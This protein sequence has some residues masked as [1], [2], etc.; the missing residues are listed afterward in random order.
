MKS[1]RSVYLL[2]GATAE[3]LPPTPGVILASRADN[4]V[5]LVCKACGNV[6]EAAAQYLRIV[7]CGPGEVEFHVNTDPTQRD[8]ALAEAMA[9]VVNAGTKDGLPL[10]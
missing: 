4:K 1:V 8:D 6:R 9:L 5:P 3:S 10:A 7:E 2:R